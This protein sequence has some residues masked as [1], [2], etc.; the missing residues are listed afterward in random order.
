M[1]QPQELPKRKFLR[2]GHEGEGMIWKDGKNSSFEKKTKN[3]KQ[4]KQNKTKKNNI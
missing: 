1:R 2:D 3:K 4:K